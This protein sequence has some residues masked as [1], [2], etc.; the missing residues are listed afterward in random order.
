MPAKENLSVVRGDTLTIVVVMTTDGVTPINITGRTYAM[1]L[2]T[3][4]EAT[5][6]AATF[7]CTLTDPTNG[8]VTCVLPAATSA[9]LTPTSYSYDLQETASGVV[10]T[11]VVGSIKVNADTTR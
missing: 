10:S 2:R 4:P 5:A 11:I 1:Q 7:T 8:E 6:V 9:G 3:A